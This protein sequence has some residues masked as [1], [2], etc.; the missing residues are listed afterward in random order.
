MVRSSLGSVAGGSRTVWDEE[1]EPRKYSDMV[2]A[3]ILTTRSSNDLARSNSITA[4]RHPFRLE[5]SF[6]TRTRRPSLR[7]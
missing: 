3:E 7:T 1:A 5:S 6:S 2:G 4:P